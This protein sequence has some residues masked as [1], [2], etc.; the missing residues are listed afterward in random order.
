MVTTRNEIGG[1]A[2]LIKGLIGGT[3]GMVGWRVL[4]PLQFLTITVV[5]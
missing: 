4:M 3:S 2:E 5:N 1:G